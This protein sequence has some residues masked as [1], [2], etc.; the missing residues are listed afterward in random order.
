M[1]KSCG[2][3][4]LILVFALLAAPPLAQ[5]QQTFT[6]PLLPTQN[7]P[8]G[9][10]GG[11][12]IA[13]G[14]GQ[15]TV[16]ISLRGL[17]AHTVYTVW[18]VFNVLECAA[19]GAGAEVPSTSASVYPDFPRDGNGVSPTAPLGAGFTSGM[20]MDPGL[21]VVT[22]KDGNGDAEIQLDFDIVSQ[23]PV[24]S[25]DII[26]QCGP[27]PAVGWDATAG[28]I[29]AAG[30]KPLRITT[31][32]LRRFIGEFPVGQRQARCANYDPHLDQDLP[33]YDVITAKGQNSAL[34]Q[35]VN[36][37]NGLP[38]VVF[39]TFDHFRLANHPDELTHGFIGG[40]PT[41]HFIDMVGRRC[42]LQPA[43]AN[44]SVCTN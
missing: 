9:A 18:T 33:S 24:S 22:D 34:W 32:W 4:L 6:L 44:P 42:D 2:V 30:S 23:A 7:A 13:S 1:K 31:T 10:E 40:N 29:C 16:K 15:S 25:R 12:T 21:N 41:D 8:A 26:R 39:Y 43:P 17:Y 28:S 3:S 35:C 37:A 5:A 11:M 27:M 19:C 14:S 36:P 20:G 38:R